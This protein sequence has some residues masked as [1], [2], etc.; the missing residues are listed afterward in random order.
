MG[1]FHS[2]LQCL[3]L[4]YERLERFRTL[5]KPVCLHS[6]HLCVVMEVGLSLVELVEAKLDVCQRVLETGVVSKSEEGVW[7]E[8]GRER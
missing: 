6:I 5:S 2:G 1:Q 4:C 3:V 8:G 7:L